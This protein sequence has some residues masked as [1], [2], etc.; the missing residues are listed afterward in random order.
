MELIFEDK[1]YDRLEVDADYFHGF[2][3]SVVTLYRGRL[4]LLRAAHAER[5]LT[6]MRCLCFKPLPA[7][8]R[9]QHSIRLNSRYCLIV[10]LQ[11]RSDG[12]VAQIVVVRID[13]I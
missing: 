4:Q 7:R 9:P 5:D 11:R 13:E 10:E 6:T 2:A 8:A 1:D 12:E 3:A